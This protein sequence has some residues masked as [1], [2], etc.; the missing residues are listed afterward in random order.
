MTDLRE[1]RGTWV[2]VVPISKLKLTET[3]DFEFRIDRVTFVASDRLARRRKRFGLPHR[4]SELR[5]KRKGMLEKFFD[6]APCFA[7]IRRKG[8]LSDFE[9]AVLE[10]IREELSILALSQLGYCKR[11]DISC[12]SISE[13]NPIRSRSL[14]V[15]NADDGSGIQANRICVETVAVLGHSLDQ[16]IPTRHLGQS[17]S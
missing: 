3:V 1:Q 12:P 16:F 7:T 17:L 4:I 8:K 13:E 11:G 14:Y 15:T 2:F 5:E 6:W 9:D 10:L